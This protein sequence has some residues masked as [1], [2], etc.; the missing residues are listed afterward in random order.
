MRPDGT[1]AR[2][3]AEAP[4]SVNL[5]RYERALRCTVERWDYSSPD[6]CFVRVETHALAL[7]R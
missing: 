2:C 5:L 4:N 1:A 3:A 7:A 6:R